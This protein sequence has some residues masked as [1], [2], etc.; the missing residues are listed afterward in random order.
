MED[1]LPEHSREDEPSAEE[2]SSKEYDEEESLPSKLADLLQNKFSGI[3][4]GRGYNDDLQSVKQRISDLE[5]KTENIEGQEEDEVKNISHLSKRI[6]ELEQD[7]E[8]HEDLEELRE[9]QEQI[10]EEKA[11]RESLKQIKEDIES[12]RDIESHLDEFLT[13]EDIEEI[14]KN[15]KDLEEKLGGVEKDLTE[16]LNDKADRKEI[17]DLEE[18]LKDSRE[19]RFSEIEE[20]LQS[21][22]E[23]TENKEKEL[24]KEIN[25]SASDESLEELR[26]EVSDLRNDEFLLEEKISSIEQRVSKVEE[27]TDKI[28]NIDEHLQS[29]DSRME[30]VEAEQK[31]NVSKNELDDIWSQLEEKADRDELKDM[32]Y[33]ARQQN[34]QEKPE[35][36]GDSKKDEENH[37]T[38]VEPGETEKKILRDNFDQKKSVTPSAVSRRNKGKELKVQGVLTLQSKSSDYY[39]YTLEGAEDIIGVIAGEKV[40]DGQVII[41]GTLKEIDDSLYL[42][43]R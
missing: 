42:D 41:E 33:F 43:L 9:T 13:A 39:L 24:E 3:L 29:I 32:K 26:E 27:K 35:S 38:S 10:K 2:D 1:V 28:S 15:V 25:R 23:R 40:E 19:T 8:K 36:T 17:R 14:E 34:S 12:L 7:E 31:E 6:R 4:P 20:Q 37:E 16:S 21:I 30:E 18:R 22:E 5:K 11:D